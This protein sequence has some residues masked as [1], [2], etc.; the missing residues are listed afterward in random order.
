MVGEMSGREN[1]LVGKCPVG[2]ASVGEV[3]SRKIVQSGKSPS[4]K[5]QWGICP[6]GSISWGTAQSGNF[7]TIS[8]FLEINPVPLYFFSLKMLPMERSSESKTSKKNNRSYFGLH[9]FLF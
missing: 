4:G 5:C 8:F 1:V 2:E 9:Q 3:S 7:P 6:R